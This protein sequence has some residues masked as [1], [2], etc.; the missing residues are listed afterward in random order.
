MKLT[1]HIRS[2][3]A[4]IPAIV[5]IGS[6]VV[7]VFGRSVWRGEIS[8]M[9][10][11]GTV[12]KSPM[13]TIT[14][15]RQWSYGYVYYFYPCFLIARFYFNVIHYFRHCRVCH[16]YPC[17]KFFFV[18]TYQLRN[19]DCCFLQTA[20]A[21]CRRHRTILRVTI[22]MDLNIRVKKSRLCDENIG[23]SLLTFEVE[24]FSSSTWE[25]SHVHAHRLS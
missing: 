4:C 3:A 9:S 8:C 11:T 14:S 12:N 2:N 1:W 15:T 25:G 6:Q 22:R 5:V 17:R 19:T 10:I 18:I 24:K 13:E 7:G 16:E 23:G 21:G 20:T